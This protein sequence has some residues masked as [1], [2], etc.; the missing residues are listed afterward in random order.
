MMP[1]KLYFATW[2]RQ[3]TPPIDALDETHFAPA[4]IGVEMV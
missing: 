3:L 4:S 2:P 1:G